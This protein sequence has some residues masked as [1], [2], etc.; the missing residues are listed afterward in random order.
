M[1]RIRS[2]AKKNASFPVIPWK[3]FVQETKQVNET[4]DEEGVR[5]V[6]FYLN[7]IAEVT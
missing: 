7:E 5:N 2:L 6:A 4:A 3:A 1:P